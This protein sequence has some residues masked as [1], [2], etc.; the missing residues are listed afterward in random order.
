MTWKQIRI[1]LEMLKTKAVERLAQAL[2]TE[3]R[4]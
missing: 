2:E 1:L 3:G 4:G